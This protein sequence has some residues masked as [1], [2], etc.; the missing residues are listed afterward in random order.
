MEANGVTA[1][2]FSYV[3]CDAINQLHASL[4][5]LSP[6]RLRSDLRNMPLCSLGSI[7]LNILR[8]V[9]RSDVPLQKTLPIGC[10]TSTHAIS[11]TQSRHSD[12]D[13]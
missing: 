7:E 6:I 1:Q 13:T 9:F 8:H 2:Q 3:E 5:V 4:Q 11:L 12:E 10:D